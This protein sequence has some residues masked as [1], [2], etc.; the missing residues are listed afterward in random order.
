MATVL[1][2]R[3][4]SAATG[5]ELADVA[6]TNLDLCEK[7]DIEVREFVLL[8]VICDSDGVQPQVLSTLL[9]ISR[10]TVDY[11]L[12]NMVENGLVRKTAEIFGDYCATADG[13][14]LIRTA[15]D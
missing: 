7:Y 8:A 14:R 3:I 4:S 15:A 6:T 1:S 13:K 5:Q 10:T 12:S 9:E 2:E 11:C